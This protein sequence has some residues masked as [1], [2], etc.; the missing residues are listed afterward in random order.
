[1]A[2]DDSSD[3]ANKSVAISFDDG[4]R[5]STTPQLF[6]I[7]K[8]KDVHVT[9]FLFGKNTEKYSQIAKQASEEGH[10]IGNHTL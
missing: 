2:N 6:E 8:S 3:E 7:I 4:P 5:Q 1:M 10:E 9:F